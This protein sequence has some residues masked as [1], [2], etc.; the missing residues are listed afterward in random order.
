MCGPATTW[1]GSEPL[2]LA[3]GREAAGVGFGHWNRA[4]L[5]LCHTRQG[6]ACI[7]LRGNNRSGCISKAA[8]K[9]REELG[10]AARRSAKGAA[11]A[12]VEVGTAGGR[13]R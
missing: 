6:V 10:A 2:R 1:D 9:K 7:P 8:G 13:V 5:E 12:G 4:A 11:V 3:E